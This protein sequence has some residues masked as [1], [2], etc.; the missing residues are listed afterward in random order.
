[1][2]DTV[3]EPVVETRVPKKGQGVPK[4]TP[5]QNS[6][7]DLQ[8]ILAQRF[9]DVRWDRLPRELESRDFF[10]A[11]M[12]QQVRIMAEASLAMLGDFY[13]PH[14]LIPALAASPAE[15]VRG[16]AAFAVPVVYPDA[17]EAQ[18]EVLHFTCALEGTWPRELSATV[19]H[20]LII[21]H[22]V[23]AVLPRVERWVAEPTPAIRRLVVES[24]RPRGVMLAHITELKQD[25]SPLKSIL[26]TLLDDGSDYVRKAVANNLNDVSRDNPGIALAWAGEW[27]THDATPERVWILARGLRT[28]ANQG[29]RTALDILGYTAASS[30]GLFWKETTPRSVSINQLLPFEFEISN[31]T[32]SEAQ[33]ILLMMMDAPGK[34]QGRRTSRYQIWKGQI[35]PGSSKRIEKRIHFVDKSTQRKEPG[36][37]RF[38]V[39]LNGHVRGEREAEFLR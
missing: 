20:N 27:M 23:A 34:G 25:P 6:I 30:L 38:I 21:Q 9:P 12:Q 35:G 22:G 37:Y 16:V 29:D 19:L 36:T 26:E 32:S 8:S 2:T 10:Q 14:D 18:V 28:L 5:E 24:F 17:P 39:T 13:D 3:K 11:G 1:M 4:E 31:P 15:K 33:V 7:A